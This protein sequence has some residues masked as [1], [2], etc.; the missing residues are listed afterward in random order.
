M[1]QSDD[2]SDDGWMVVVAVGV[3]LLLACWFY[4]RLL[5]DI[6]DESEC[7][8]IVEAQTH[9]ASQMLAQQPKRET[10]QAIKN[11]RYM[12][13]KSGYFYVLDYTG[14]MYCHGESGIEGKYDMTSPTCPLPF[15]KPVKDIVAVARKGGGFL[16]YNW[17]GG[18]K[19]TYVCPVAGSNLIICSGL[20]TDTESVK[21]RKRWK[22]V[23]DKFTKKG[24]NVQRIK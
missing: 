20:M 3:L 17:K 9:L 23:G 21:R 18:Q 15:S 16:K 13:D 19:S 14:H 12:P 22:K 11:L 7:K 6:R 5:S 10:I 4:A 24:K 1:P 8:D 2:G